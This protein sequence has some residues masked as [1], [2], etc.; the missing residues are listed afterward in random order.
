MIYEVDDDGYFTGAN[1]LLDKVTDSKHQTAIPLPDGTY[2][3]AKFDFTNQKWIGSDRPADFDK[4][5]P[6]PQQTINANLMLQVAT[7]TAEIS[8]LKGSAS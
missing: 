2:L 7:L 5:N 3:P 1:A 4:V 8:K 6:S